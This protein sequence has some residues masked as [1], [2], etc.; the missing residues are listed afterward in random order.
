MT[1]ELLWDKQNAPLESLALSR[2]RLSQ[3][4]PFLGER[5]GQREGEVVLYSLTG[6]VNIYAEGQYIG[7]IGN[8]RTMTEEVVQAVRLRGFQSYAVTLA[9]HCYAAD[10]LVLRHHGAHRVDTPMVTLHFNDT[11]WHTVGEGCHQRRVGEVPTPVGAEIFCGETHNIVGGISS[12]PPHA[13]EKDIERFSNGETTWQE[14]M[15]FVCEKPGIANL[16]GVY[17]GGTVVNKLVEIRNGDAMAM[18]L[19]SHAIH[20]APDSAM[21]YV[22]GYVGTALQKQ[23]N[24]SATDVTTYRK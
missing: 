22:W 24:Q 19:G 3:E 1:I 2:I 13:T 5:D 16:K 15:F 8:R 7:L 10:M 17:T 9:S 23:Y 4:S 18:P 21:I 12:W 20:A 11:A 14:V 6:S